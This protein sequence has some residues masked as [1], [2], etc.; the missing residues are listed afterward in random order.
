MSKQSN[1]N[2]PKNNYF[3]LSLFFFF[4][5]ETELP[6]IDLK[7]DSAYCKDTKI[8]H[9]GTVVTHQKSKKQT[10]TTINKSKLTDRNNQQ[11]NKNK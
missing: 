8:D 2:H 4:R 10:N 11:D 3:F 1:V 7:W 5:Q 9:T 6:P